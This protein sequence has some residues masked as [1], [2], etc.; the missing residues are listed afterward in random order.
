MSKSRFLLLTGCAVTMAVPAAHAAPVQAMS[1][2]AAGKPAVLVQVAGFKQARGQLKISLYGDD[3]SRWLAKKG[4]IAKVKVPVT[5]R[6]M[7]V[8]IPVPAPG[9]Y[10]VAVHHDFNLNGDRDVQDGGGY[11]R[12]PKVTLLNP[13]PAFSRAAFDV[14]NG[15]ARVG[16]TLLYIRGL[17]VGPTES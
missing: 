12:N 14:G 5:A 13:K 6:A 2:C 8:C 1:N 16:V 3:S 17:G 11:S 4:R 7:N 9:R 10:A 15:P